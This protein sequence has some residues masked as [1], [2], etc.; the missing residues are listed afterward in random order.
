MGDQEIYVGLGR[1]VD[2]KL[3]ITGA[4]RGGAGGAPAVAGAR[5][6]GGWGNRVAWGEGCS[7]GWGDGGCACG[8]GQDRVG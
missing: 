2:V 7:P 5:A 8:W 3:L 1:A 4:G 6:W